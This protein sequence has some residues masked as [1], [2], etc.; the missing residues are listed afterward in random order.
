MALLRHFRLCGEF[1]SHI[2]R[3]LRR[4]LVRCFDHIDLR[5]FRILNS[6]RALIRLGSTAPANLEV[7]DAD[8]E[9]GFERPFHPVSQLI[10]RT[11]SGQPAVVELERTVA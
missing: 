6:D 7:V 2:F 1:A 8:T 9:M 11:S 4:H 10:M 5:L 3:R